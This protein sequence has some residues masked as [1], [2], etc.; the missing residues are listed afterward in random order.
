[1]AGIDNITKVIAQ[2]AEVESASIISAAEKAAEE[3][4]AKATGEAD[5]LK[6]SA[7]EKLDRKIAAERKKIESQSEHIEK[8]KMLETKQTIIEDTLKKA[9]D[10]LLGYDDAAY[11]ETLL[12][13]LE[14]VV[15]ADKGTLLLS[16]K[17]LGRIPADFESKV[18]AVATKKGGM[19]DI[20]KQAA[21]INGGF[22]LNYGDIEINS[23]LDAVFDENKE[24]LVDIVNSLLF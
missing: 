21:D 6:L 10:K 12:G 15:Q 19:L 23:S 8:L 5:Q 22:I 17:D 2:D 24:K 11:F 7:K 13:L 4:R 1:M 20:S 9:K 16:E 18:N 14:K 3:A